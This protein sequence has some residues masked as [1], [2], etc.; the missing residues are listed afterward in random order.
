MKLMYTCTECVMLWWLQPIRVRELSAKKQR[1][2]VSVHDD[3]FF[4]TELAQQNLRQHSLTYNFHY[5][6]LMIPLN[7]NNSLVYQIFNLINQIQWNN[8]NRVVQYVK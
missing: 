2:T 4:A 6:E 7:M 8:L 1:T 3:P 5:S